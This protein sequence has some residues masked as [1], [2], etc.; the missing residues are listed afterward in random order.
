M[1]AIYM[2]VYQGQVSFPKKDWSAWPLLFEMMVRINKNW[3]LANLFGQKLKAD[4]S[5]L[6]P[7]LI[8][9]FP[10]FTCLWK[11]NA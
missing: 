4:K 7:I 10:N 1:C 5:T 6:Q 8:I 2:L 3:F 11:W 9:V